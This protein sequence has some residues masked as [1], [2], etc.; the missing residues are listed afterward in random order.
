MPGCL[1]HPE[2]YIR[3]KLHLIA[4]GHRSERILRLGPCAEVDGGAGLLDE[5]EM[6][7][8]VVGM[9]MGQEDVANLQPLRRGVGEVPVDVTLRVYDGRDTGRLIGNQIRGMGQTA[10]VV[11]LQNH[12]F[13]NCT[14]A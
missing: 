11:L 9:K 4:I 5:L 14:F 7:R 10:E 12:L 6:S 2:T 3:P 8:D 1:E 13:S